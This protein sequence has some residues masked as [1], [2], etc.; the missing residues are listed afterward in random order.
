M[1]NV[2]V[3]ARSQSHRN[4]HHDQETGQQLHHEADGEN[5]VTLAGDRKMSKRASVL[6][7]LAIGIVV[8]A[9]RA[10]AAS[11][12]YSL[13]VRGQLLNSFSAT[14]CGDQLGD[15]YDTFCPSG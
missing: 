10:R 14:T 6:I 1:G 2:L 9:P 13:N 11:P 12:A 4:F 8:L 7:A 5:T 15:S 3:H